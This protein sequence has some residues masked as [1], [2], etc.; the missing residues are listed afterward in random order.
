MRVQ[1]QVGNKWGPQSRSSFQIRSQTES[2][3]LNLLPSLV[4]KLSNPRVTGLAPRH[5]EEH[6]WVFRRCGTPPQNVAPRG[7]LYS[8]AL[9]SS[10]ASAVDVFGAGCGSC[11]CKVKP[12]MN[13]NLLSTLEGRNG[14]AKHTYDDGRCLTDPRGIER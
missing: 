13:F 6:P 1:T 7:R 5:W 11:E 12:I 14:K 9:N 10:K 8:G 4:N 3:Q 2:W